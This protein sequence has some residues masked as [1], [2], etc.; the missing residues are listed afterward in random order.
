MI[1]EVFEFNQRA[2][3]IEPRV[4]L[5]FKS[6][7]KEVDFLR[8]ALVEEGDELLLASYN[9]GPDGKLCADAVAIVHQVDACIDAAYFSIGGLARLGLTASQAVAC[10]S[11]IH[12]ANMTKKLGTT[13]R[14]DVGVPDG[15]KPPDWVGPE[16]TIARILFG[17]DL[18]TLERFAKEGK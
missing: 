13:H 4:A 14:G 11:A 1:L 15:T 7:S 12:Q 3:G 9:I 6:P 17:H 10:F 16:N 8:K 2:L 5:G 18:A